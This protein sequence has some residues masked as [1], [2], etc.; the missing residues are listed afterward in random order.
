MTKQIIVGQKL[1]K[2]SL[3]KCRGGATA[4][5]CSTTFCNNGTRCC[6]GFYCRIVAIGAIAFVGDCLKPRAGNG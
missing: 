1:T 3:K 5:V 4:D 2:E 6:P